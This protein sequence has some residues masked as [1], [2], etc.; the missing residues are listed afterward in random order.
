[1][2][3]L[4]FSSFHHWEILTQYYSSN[5]G[6]TEEPGPLLGH[7]SAAEID[8]VI[9]RILE[10]SSLDTTSPPPAISEL[11]FSSRRRLSTDLDY[12]STGVP[13]NL[14]FIVSISDRK[15]LVPHDTG[16]LV[17]SDMEVSQ[18]LVDRE[19]GHIF[20]SENVPAAGIS[21]GFDSYEDT[22]S[23]TG[24]PTVL[25]KDA[26]A[27]KLPARL[28]F[29]Q[30]QEA[31]ELR[32]K[33]W[34]MARIFQ[35][36]VA[37]GEET[38]LEFCQRLWKLCLCFKKAHFPEEMLIGLELI[39]AGYDIEFGAASKETTPFL[40]FQAQVLKQM[41]RFQE[42]ET[43]Y[44]QA[45]SGFRVLRQRVA[46]LKCQIL[47]GHLLRSQKRTSEAL[48][49]LLEALIEHF[50][51]A[52]TIEESRKVVDILE[53]IRKLHIKMELGPDL[54]ESVS[55]LKNLQHGWPETRNHLKLFSEFVQLGGHY[56]KLG[57]YELA[58]LFFAY[59]LS[60]HCSRVSVASKIEFLKRSCELSIHYQRQRKLI[61]SIEK[62]KFA[63]EQFSDLLQQKALERTDFRWPSMMSDTLEQDLFAS[64]GK[65]LER[66]EP[67]KGEL[68]I[69]SYQVS[70]WS[71]WRSV[72]EEWVKLHSRRRTTHHNPIRNSRLENLKDR[73][74]MQK[75]DSTSFSSHGS[76]KI[77]SSSVGSRFGTTYSVGSA[78]SIVSN[79]VFMVP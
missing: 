5:P 73:E 42:S 58:D 26:Q 31:V 68:I 54:T 69:Q 67:A 72:E 64:L 39:Q 33:G 51:W 57:K 48:Q 8:R 2:P 15:P 23:D 10:K 11:Q 55:R 76:S 34:S 20:L 4:F 9:S 45:I 43:L 50:A 27:W 63:V 32:E 60:F 77:S 18:T 75:S 30:K 44:R 53:F 65:L 59:R 66:T 56:S 46:Q 19:L 25:E 16:P 13:R 74:I 28:Y 17:E 3:Q 24:S 52:R 41:N 6:E 35:H 14:P 38:S 71:I 29:R 61:Q 40:A 70:L 12:L 22:F 36:L 49:L 47:L 21:T 1:M 37:C 7:E 79:S 62:L 78:S